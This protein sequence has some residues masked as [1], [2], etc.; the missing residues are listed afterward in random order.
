MTYLTRVEP[1]NNVNRW[2]FVTVQPTLFEPLAVICF[3]G[4][5]GTKYQRAR[6]LPADT[7]AEAEELAGSIVSQ[8]LARGYCIKP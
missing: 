1:E 7:A 3:W 5:R 6:I 4:R 8:K 2:Y